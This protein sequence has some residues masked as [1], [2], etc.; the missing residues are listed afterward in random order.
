[1]GHSSTHSMNPHLGIHNFW[2]FLLTGILLNITPGQDTFYI[3]GRTLAQGRR[4]GLA[5]VLG[6]STGSLMH[7]LLAATGLSMVLATSASAFMLVK[8]AGAGYLVFLGFRMLLSRHQTGQPATAFAAASPVAIFRQGLLTNLLN[9][10]VA[11]FFLA[12]VPQFIAPDSGS[13]FLA[14]T[15]LGLC[16][17]ASGT[18]WCLMLV[19]CASLMSERLRENVSFANW[20][21][22]SAGA[23]FVFLGI[24]LAGSR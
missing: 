21:N 5:S 2:I 10:K 8:M 22:R 18:I 13:K 11:L 1:M 6:I 23:L 24:R 19:G 17:I 14:F 4:A 12:F 9:P 3:L 20:L 15:L 7:T 16:F